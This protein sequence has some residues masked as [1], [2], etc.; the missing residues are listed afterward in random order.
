MTQSRGNRGKKTSHYDFVYIDAVQQFDVDEYAQNPSMIRKL[1]MEREN[2]YLVIVEQKSQ[3]ETFQ[4]GLHQM[5]LQKRELELKLHEASTMIVKLSDEKIAIN[6]EKKHL[7][8]QIENTKMHSHEL[9]LQKQKLDLSLSHTQQKLS[10]AQQTSLVKFVATTAA[11][12][13]LS[14]GVNIDTSTPSDWKGW[15]LTIFSVI[16]GSIAFLIPQKGE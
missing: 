16:I 5:E 7:Q 15:V 11:A 8:S 1:H 6:E 9:E 12:I 13:M 3:L 14:F 10:E 2:A 4:S